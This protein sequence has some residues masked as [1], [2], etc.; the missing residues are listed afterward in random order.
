[1]HNFQKNSA[2]HFPERRSIVEIAMP[3]HKNKLTVKK[4]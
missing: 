2:S 1:M 4:K 3:E